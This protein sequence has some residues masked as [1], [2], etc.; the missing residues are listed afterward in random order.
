MRA[1]QIILG[2]L[3]ALAALSTGGCALAVTISAFMDWQNDLLPFLLI[4]AACFAAAWGLGWLALRFF[5]GPWPDA[6]IGKDPPQ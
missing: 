2:V 3:F 5:R 1:V 6:A 4:P